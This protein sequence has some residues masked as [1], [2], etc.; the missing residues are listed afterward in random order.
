LL[1]TVQSSAISVSDGLVE[2]RN[3]A[4]AQRSGRK[5]S[6]SREPSVWHL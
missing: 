2:E 4:A 6:A 1:A 3:H 5:E